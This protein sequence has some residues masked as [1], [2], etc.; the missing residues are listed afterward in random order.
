MRADA[1]GYSG[2]RVAEEAGEVRSGRKA[3]MTYLSR[4][5]KGTRRRGAADRIE[6]LLKSTR[7]P[8]TIPMAA[9]LVG[10]NYYSES[11]VLLRLCVEQKA[12]RRLRDSGGAEGHPGFEFIWRES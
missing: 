10:A 9:R 8:W 11:R 1:P 6:A 2:L 5:I 7:K 3:A 4:D 12:E